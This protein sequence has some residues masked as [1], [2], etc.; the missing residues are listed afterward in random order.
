MT[1]VSVPGLTRNFCGASRP[2]HFDG[3]TSVVSRLL[4]ITEPDF[5]VFGQKDYQQLVIIRR[6]IDDLHLPVKTIAGQTVREPDGLAL[7]SR[8]SYL[9]DDER[10]VAPALYQSLCECREALQS[11][12]DRLEVL[13]SNG[14]RDLTEAGFRPEYFVV[15]RAA[16]LEVPSDAAGNLVVLAAARL[17]KARLIDNVLVALPQA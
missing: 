3:V 16:D 7:S 5:A 13:E 2:G 1:L 9:T 8:N 12:E 14:E 11:G 15:R 4:N 17:G 6:M 10:S